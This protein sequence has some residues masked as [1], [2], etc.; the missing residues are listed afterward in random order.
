MGLAV[1][2]DSEQKETS[3]RLSPGR[4]W[5]QHDCTWRRLCGRLAQSE[6][7]AK[8]FVADDEELVTQ[9]TAGVL[10]RPKGIHRLNA[11]DLVS[12]LMA[13]ERV[14]GKADTIALRGIVFEAEDAAFQVETQMEELLRENEVLQQRVECVRKLSLVAVSLSPVPEGNAG[15]MEPPSPSLVMR[16]VRRIRQFSSICC[17]IAGLQQVRTLLASME[18]RGFKVAGRQWRKHIVSAA[19]QKRIGDTQRRRGTVGGLRKG[20]QE[21]IVPKTF[22]PVVRQSEDISERK[23]ILVRWGSIPYG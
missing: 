1:S 22:Q 9:V 4:E 13:L 20:P 18:S 6:S 16:I 11:T 8:A 2:G 7:E 3:L 5:A 23:L 21:R 19:A 14:L 12:K 15:A 10:A 17:E